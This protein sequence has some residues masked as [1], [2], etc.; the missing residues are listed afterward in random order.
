[1]S[2]DLI[3]QVL[4]LRSGDVIC[5]INKRD[6]VL[7]GDTPLNEIKLMSILVIRISNM[8]SARADNI[9]HLLDDYYM[10]DENDI[11]FWKSGVLVYY[12]PPAEDMN[13]EENDIESSESDDELEENEIGFIR[14]EIAIQEVKLLI[15]QSLESLEIPDVIDDVRDLIY[16]AHQHAIREEFKNSMILYVS[17][18][19]SMNIEQRKYYIEQLLKT[20]IEFPDKLKKLL[21]FDNAASYKRLLSAVVQKINSL[22]D[23]NEDLKNKKEN[24]PEYVNAFIQLNRLI[25]Y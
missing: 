11:Y 1:M 6:D 15:H 5:L 3:N 4:E 24:Q 18:F 8:N 25:E 9:C 7:P 12:N 16:H 22:F 2:D 17:N 10:E 14:A 20:F 23:E 21:L 19:S 13:F